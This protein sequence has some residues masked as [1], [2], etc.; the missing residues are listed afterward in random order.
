MRITTVS[1]ESGSTVFGVKRNTVDMSVGEMCILIPNCGTINNNNTNNNNYSFVENYINLKRRKRGAVVPRCLFGVPDPIDTEKLF[2]E[3]MQREREKLLT[4]YGIDIT[5]RNAA[6]RFVLQIIGNN[7]TTTTT[8]C[9]ADVGIPKTEDIVN[10]KNSAI[11]VYED[12]GAKDRSDNNDQTN[13]DEDRL[14]GGDNSFVANNNRKNLATKSPQQQTSPAKKQQQR[15]LH[16]TKK[17]THV[18]GGFIH[19]C[20]VKLTSFLF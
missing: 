20:S 12:D 16:S 6:R 13:E 1:V 17:Q 4:R 3:E 8:N 18:T 7:P 5:K 15:L 9:T 10:R 11:T 19:I 14:R 2:Q